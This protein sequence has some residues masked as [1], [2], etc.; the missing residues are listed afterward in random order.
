[1]V[2]APVVEMVH[3]TWC[4]DEVLRMPSCVG[5]SWTAR[6]CRVVPWLLDMRNI[7]L[8]DGI[9]VADMTT[10]SRW[11]ELL[12]FKN[13]LVLEASPRWIHVLNVTPVLTCM[14]L[15]ADAVG[16]V[17]EVIATLNCAAYVPGRGPPVD[18]Y[19]VT[20]GSYRGSSG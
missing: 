20:N 13:G 10:T 8:R 5:V 19:A 1:M 3:A 15:S 14:L 7:T 11:S 17:V 9:V 6:Y 4:H 18:V 16:S 12:R 2:H